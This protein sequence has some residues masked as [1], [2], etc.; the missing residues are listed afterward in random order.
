MQTPWGAS[1]II[2]NLNGTGCLRVDC[3]GHGGIFVPDELLPRIPKAERKLAARWSGSENWYEEDCC[4][5][6]VLH[7]IPETRAERH[8]AE[9][10]SEWHRGAVLNQLQRA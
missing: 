4:A 3:A 8:T 6:S 1:Q 5:L 10:V 7:H 2:R 9:Q